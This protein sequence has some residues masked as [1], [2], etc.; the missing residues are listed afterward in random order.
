MRAT[1]LTFILTVFTFTTS[2]VA[3]NKDPATRDENISDTSISV[4]TAELPNGLHEYTYTLTSGALNKGKI[5][6]FLL[7]ISCKDFPSN[8]IAP[9]FTTSGYG[10]NSSPDSHFTPVQLEVPHPYSPGITITNE[11]NW[12]AALIP[13]GTITDYKIT[14]PLP[15]AKRK[16]TLEPSWETRWWGYD[17]E[18][19]PEEWPW[20]D[21][22]I[23]TGMIDGPSC[24]S[25]KPP[26]YPGNGGEAEEISNLLTYTV[27]QRDRWHVN[28]DTDS[29]TLTIHY[30]EDID[31]KT[32]KTEPG[33]ARSFFNP[34]PGSTDT[35]VLNLKK[36]KNLFKF[37]VSPINPAVTNNKNKHHRDNVDR[38]VFEIRKEMKK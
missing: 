35:V 14:S 28:T 2:V 5:L 32:F 17:E 38:D 19:I 7:D 1:M 9:D 13:G 26:V 10:L 3:A 15:P 34:I 12:L 25:D 29:L 30:S 18:F 4:L 6:T 31:P 33:W 24:P 37:S 20:I 23:V 21:D 27:P 16:Y 36:G 22:F 11:I 8:E